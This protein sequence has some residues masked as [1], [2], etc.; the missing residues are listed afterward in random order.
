MVLNQIGTVA[1]TAARPIAFDR[2]SENRATGSFVLVDEV[3]NH[4]VAGGM[5][6]EIANG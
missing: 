5:I 3:T 6:S 2:Y 4:T 1:V